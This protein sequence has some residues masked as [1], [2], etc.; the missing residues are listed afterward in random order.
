MLF[1]RL[2]LFF[3]FKNLK[4]VVLLEAIFFF[5]FLHHKIKQFDF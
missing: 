1:S 2:G 5:S 3:L 4:R